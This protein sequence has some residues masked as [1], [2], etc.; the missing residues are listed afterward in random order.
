MLSFFEIIDKKK[1]F[2]KL[3][4]LQ[5][6]KIYNVFYLNLFQKTLINLLTN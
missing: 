6:I 4:L 5:S 2:I 3:H 1:V